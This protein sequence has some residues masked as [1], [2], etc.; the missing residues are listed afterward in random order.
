MNEVLD[1]LRVKLDTLGDQC[2]DIARDRALQLFRAK[3]LDG[4]PEP[5]SEEVAYW[6]GKTDAFD[7]AASLVRDFMKPQTKKG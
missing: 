1:R 4:G 5:D 7:K 2:K 6:C 3:L